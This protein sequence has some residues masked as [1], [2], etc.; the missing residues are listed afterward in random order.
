LRTAIRMHL[1]RL[2]S[3]QRVDTTRFPVCGSTRRSCRILELWADG[4]M[5]TCTTVHANEVF[6]EAATRL[7]FAATLGFGGSWPT[8]TTNLKRRPAP[9]S[10]TQGSGGIAGSVTGEGQACF[11]AAVSQLKIPNMG[12]CRGCHVEIG[13]VVF[14]RRKRR[15]ASTCIQGGGHSA[16]LAMATPRNPIL[17]LASLFYLFSNVQHSIAAQPM[18]Q[19]HNMQFAAHETPS[20]SPCSE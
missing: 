9:R 12:A 16:R 8:S 13:G 10:H 7:G 4:A 11:G 1:C 20:R 3:G 6:E 5:A 2:R 19:E 18:T 17:M 14:A 15:P